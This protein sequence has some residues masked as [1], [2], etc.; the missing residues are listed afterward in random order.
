VEHCGATC[1]PERAYSACIV[2]TPKFG[3]ILHAA[4]VFSVT[5]QLTNY[6]EAKCSILQYNS[7]YDS[8]LDINLLYHS[9]RLFLCMKF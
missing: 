3:I 2:M 1:A 6:E 5:S 8:V 9:H 7:L 4:V